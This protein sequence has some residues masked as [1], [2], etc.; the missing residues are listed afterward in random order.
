MSNAVNVV[1][2][3]R[4]VHNDFNAADVSP[5]IESSSSVTQLLFLIASAT[6]GA[7]V[8]YLT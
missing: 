6:V 8:V 3:W 7:E 5:P 1:L 4:D 2:P